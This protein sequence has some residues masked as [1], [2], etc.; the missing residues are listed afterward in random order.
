MGGVDKV[1]DE[2]QGNHREPEDPGEIRMMGNALEACGTSHIL[3]IHDDNA[4]DFP[5]AQSGD[6]QIVA[7]QAQSRYANE[8]PQESRRQ[9]TCQQGCHE[10]SVEIGSE[11]H[12][13]IGSHRHEASVA[14]R[15]L[16]GVAVDEIEAHRHDD[17]DANDQHIELPEGAQH[18]AGNQPLQ[19]REEHNGKAQEDS[20]IFSQVFHAF[21]LIH[22]ATSSDLFLG[23]LAED[24]RR[25]HQQHDNQD[26]ES[27][28]ITEGG[29]NKA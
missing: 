26:G 19:K 21:E 28:R 5:K 17:I 2:E 1:L 3:D 8:E 16:P 11:H 27:R 29:G 4:D 24:A 13:H 18:L 23:I 6:S 12:A 14:Q 20:I 9:A 15:K 10:R 7:V 25:T 22:A